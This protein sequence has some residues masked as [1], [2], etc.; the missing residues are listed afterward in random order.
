VPES[1][2]ALPDNLILMFA[3]E[4]DDVEDLEVQ[5]ADKPYAAGIPLKTR[6]QRGRLRVHLPE[7]ARAMVQDGA[8][9][10]VKYRTPPTITQCPSALQ[11]VIDDR[12]YEEVQIVP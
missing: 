11:C 3:G 6:W 9:M 12:T 8:F 7:E 1:E 4:R 2:V 10:S 5:L